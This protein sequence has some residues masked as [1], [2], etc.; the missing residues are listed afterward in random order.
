M[1]KALITGINGQDASYLAEFLIQKNYDVVGLY[2]RSSTPDF[3]RLTSI[4]NSPKLK[5]ICGDVTDYGSM[6]SIITQEWPDEIYNLAAQSYV[7]ASFDQPAYTASATF[8]GCLNILEVL[9]YLSQNKD[10]HEKYR[11][12]KLYQASSS[13]MFGDSYD[14]RSVQK[15]LS[16][17]DFSFSTVFYQNE[18]TPFNPQSPYAVAKLAA[19]HSCKLYRKAY[20]IFV[21][22]GILFNHE[23]PRRGDE[24]VTKKIANYIK[25]LNSQPGIDYIFKRDAV[26][27][28]NFQKLK[29]GNLYARRDWGYAGDYVKAMWLMLQAKTPDDYVVCTGETHS[30]EEFLVEAFMLIG[31]DNILPFVEIDEAL[32]RPAE[33]SYLCGS[34]SKAKEKLGWEPSVKFQ[35]LVRLMVNGSP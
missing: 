30:V 35:E 16:E 25:W 34:Y 9:K 32:K 20:G 28:D 22:S 7:A 8:I 11:M 1:P 19:H 26:L 14:V 15:N 6:L 21:C 31:V 27:P 3:S 23:S 33:V 4:I 10:M 13:E 18:N 12:P 2:R 24:F 5:L 29:L 17:N